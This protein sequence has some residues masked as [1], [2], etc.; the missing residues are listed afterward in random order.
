MTQ[1]HDLEQVTGTRFGAIRTRGTLVDIDLR[2]PV[3]VHVNRIERT[4]D[5]TVAE[6]Q[7]SPRA[8]LAS[9]RHER[10]RPT[11]L[12]TAVFGN[13]MR[14]GA[15]PAA[16]ETRHHFFLFTGI[17]LEILRYRLYG[18]FGAYRALTR[19]DLAG[20]QLFGK[21][22][23][24][25]LSTGTAI[26]ARQQFV[27]PF[28]PGILINMQK[29]AGHGDDH[30]EEETYTGHYGGCDQNGIHQLKGSALFI[31]SSRPGSFGFNGFPGCIH[32]AGQSSAALTSSS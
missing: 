25:G 7:A 20:N 21:G 14:L 1:G 26:G 13:L 17:D 9:A 18:L 10:R 27:G 11:A 19:R 12:E 16:L 2:K 6:A 30:A 29:P 28:D 23:T 8:S 32:L 22:E 5:F 4:G 31:S 24:T 15:A 3:A